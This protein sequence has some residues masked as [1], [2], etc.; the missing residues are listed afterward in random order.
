MEK[1]VVKGS[2][3]NASD[4]LRQV[5]GN[6]RRDDYDDEDERATANRRVKMDP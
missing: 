1:K 5:R 3:I 4:K 2:E 6:G